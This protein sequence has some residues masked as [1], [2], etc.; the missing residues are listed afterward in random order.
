MAIAASVILDNASGILLDVARRTWTL[1]DLLAYLNEALSATAFVKPDM[2]VLQGFVTPAAG[3]DQTLPDGSVALINI[4]RNATGRVIAQCDPELLAEANRFWPRATLQAEAENFAADPRDPLRYRIFPPNNGLGSIE[5]IRGAVPPRITDPAD[6][7]A[8]PAS[9]EHPLTNFVLSRAYSKNSKK[10][11]PTKQAY[12]MQQWGSLLGL[13]S[14]A[15]IT[16]APHVAQV[17]GTP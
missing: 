5:V 6:T 8:V 14:Q 10:A 7:L 11:D 15:Q 1:A 2:Y 4:T 3:V 13:K 17:P 12:Y 9:Y 16:V